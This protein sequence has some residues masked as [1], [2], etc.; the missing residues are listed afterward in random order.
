MT[1]TNAC[2]RAFIWDQTNCMRSVKSVLT[3]AGVDIGT[4]LLRMA[5]GESADGRVVV[6]TGANPERK[7]EYA[8]GAMICVPYAQ[9]RSL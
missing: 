5:M 6:G 8:A 1:D 4:W 3:S 7:V 9:P 2:T